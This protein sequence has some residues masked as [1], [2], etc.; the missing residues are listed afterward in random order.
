MTESPYEDLLRDVFVNGTTK[1]DRTKTGTRSVF[2]RMA[3]FK[4]ADGFPLVTTKHVSFNAIANELLWFIRGES[5][6]TWLREQGVTIWDEWADENGELGPIYG[7]QWMSWPTPNGGVINQLQ[8]VIDTIK[9]DPSSRRLIVSAWNP[10]D[11]P[12]MALAPCHVLFQFYVTDDGKLSCSLYQR[13]A[14]M[15][16]GVPYN[17]ASYALLLNMVALLCDLE[18]GDFVWMGGDLHIYDNHEDQVKTQLERIPFKLSTLVIKRKPELI[19]GFTINDFELLDYLH[20]PTI[21]AP[22]AV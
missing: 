18:V 9:K 8:D 11:I 16:L 3:R 17:I 2:G 22:V 19:T 13:S 6:V 7:V 1:K 12:K 14:D 4:A 21:S 20:H 15:F 10:A 5:N